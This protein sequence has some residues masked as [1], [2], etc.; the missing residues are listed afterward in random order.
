MVALAWGVWQAFLV[1]PMPRRL[2][3]TGRPIARFLDP[4]RTPIAGIVAGRPGAV[5]AGQ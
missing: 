2:V 1:G 4:D 5:T 3:T